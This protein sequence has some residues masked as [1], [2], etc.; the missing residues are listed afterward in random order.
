MIENVTT[1]VIEAQ[2]DCKF[3]PLP[4]QELESLETEQTELMHSLTSNP[5]SKSMTSRMPLP[6]TEL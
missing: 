5:V 1:V 3:T 2:R 4:T 6:A